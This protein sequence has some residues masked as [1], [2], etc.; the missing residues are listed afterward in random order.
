MISEDPCGAT[1]LAKPACPPTPNA[2]SHPRGGRQGRPTCRLSGFSR[3]SG[4]V[5]AEPYPPLKQ[6]EYSSWGSRSN[7][8]DQ[9]FSFYQHMSLLADTVVSSCWRRDS[10]SE[11]GGEWPSAIANGKQPIANGQSGIG[12]RQSATP[13][14]SFRV[15]SEGEDED[16]KKNENEASFR[17]PHSALRITTP[18][19]P[20]HL[21][22]RG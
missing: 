1:C 2:R 22:P 7:R 8:P 3:R 12:V 15:E 20:D 6:T 21:P 10:K 16:E 17:I 9:S 13:H 18:P 4:C 19:H 11:T 5:P 14:S